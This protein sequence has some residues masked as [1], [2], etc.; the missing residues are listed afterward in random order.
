MATTKA[1]PST[2][3]LSDPALYINREV[4]WL[5][6]NARVLALARD[7][8]QPL[9]ER[10]KFLAIFSSN[11]DEFFMVRVAGLPGRPRGR[12]ALVDAADQMPREEVLARVAE[13]VRELIR[14]QSRIWPRR[15][16]ELAQ[17]GIEI[18]AF[19]DLR[20]AERLEVRRAVFD[21]EVYPVLT[22]LAVGPGHPFPTSPGCRS[23]WPA[24]CATR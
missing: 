24:A 8:A 3:D 10:C 16:A 11:L 12:P 20:T 23:T 18:A 5:D 14:E 6:F 15:S 9:L 2:P 17:A 13:R 22:P 21:R 19:R 4:S 1:A 7:T